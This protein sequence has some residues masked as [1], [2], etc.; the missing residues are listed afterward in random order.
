MSESATRVNTEQQGTDV[1]QDEM[2][3]KGP[4]GNAWERGHLKHLYTM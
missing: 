2:G 4:L 3:E 1:A